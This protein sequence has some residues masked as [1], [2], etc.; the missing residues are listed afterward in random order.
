MNHE[1][2]GKKNKKY[3]NIVIVVLIFAIS[4]IYYKGFTNGFV[5]ETPSLGKTV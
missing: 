5:S 4:L 2:L 3:D 1:V